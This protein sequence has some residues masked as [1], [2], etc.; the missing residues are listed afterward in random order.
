MVGVEQGDQHFKLVSADRVRQEADC[1][2][3][4]AFNGSQHFQRITHEVQLAFSHLIGVEDEVL[5]LGT[6]GEDELGALLLYRPAAVG[7]EVAFAV[8]E[9]KGQAAPVEAG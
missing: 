2:A 5:G 1:I 3:D 4:A 9:G 7:R 8:V 6:I